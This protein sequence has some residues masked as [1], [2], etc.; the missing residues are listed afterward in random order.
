MKN[1]VQI[2]V[3]VRV[4]ILEIANIKNHH[5]KQTSNPFP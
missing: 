2:I 4:A 3:A 5:G 1:F